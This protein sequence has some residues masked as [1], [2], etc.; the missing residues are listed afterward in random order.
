[1][2]SIHGTFPRDVDQSVSGAGV[3][4]IFQKREEWEEG[5]GRKWDRKEGGG[6]E[7]IIFLTPEEQ[8][9]GAEREL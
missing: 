7:R 9:A 4:L 6:A 3:N 8:L 1:M 2:T 5:K